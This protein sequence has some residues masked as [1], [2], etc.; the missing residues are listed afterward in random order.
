MLHFE[1]GTLFFYTSANSTRRYLIFPLEKCPQ[2]VLGIVLFY[3]TYVLSVIRLI[4]V[5]LPQQ[6]TPMSLLAILLSFNTTT[7]ASDRIANVLT[8]DLLFPI[9]LF[10]QRRDLFIPS[11]HRASWLPDG[12]EYD[13]KAYG[14][15]CGRYNGRKLRPKC[16]GKNHPLRYCGERDP[17]SE[18]L[19]FRPKVY[20]SAVSL[21]ACRPIM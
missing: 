6:P 9:T 11:S 4:K 7:T 19:L 20:L 8:P 3:R 14:S 17:F 18:R 12:L 15:P 16:Y 5:Q 13:R 21:A 2:N 10:E 1:D